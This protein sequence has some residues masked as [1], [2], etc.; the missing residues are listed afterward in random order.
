M[1]NTSGEGQIK[2]NYRYDENFKADR[3]V[4]IDLAEEVKKFNTTSEKA[5]SP[6]DRVAE[7]KK[8]STAIIKFDYHL[9]MMTKKYPDYY[10]EIKKYIDELLQ[11][12]GL[13]LES[14]LDLI[15]VLNK[16]IN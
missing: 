10:T 9:I 11:Q 13:F 14:T 5:I 12:N 2:Y 6:I 8:L 7:L 3:Q 16:N 15:R 4:Y 1:K